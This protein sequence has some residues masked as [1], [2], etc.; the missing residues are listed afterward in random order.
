VEDGETAQVLCD[1]GVD[2]AQ[3][4]YFGRPRLETGQEID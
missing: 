4:H 2:W 1:V 3:G